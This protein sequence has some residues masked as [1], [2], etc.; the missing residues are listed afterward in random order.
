MDG[1]DATRLK[2]WIKEKF[3][4]EKRI[5]SKAE[6]LEKIDVELDSETKGSWSKT[7]SLE[8]LRKLEAMNA[9]SEVYL[10]PA[11]QKA[12]A[13][14]IQVEK[15]K[16]PIRIELEP[17]SEPV[18]Y[19]REDSKES[20]SF[21]AKEYAKGADWAT[22]NL[23]KEEYQKVR[24]WIDEKDKSKTKEDSER[25]INLVMGSPE[26]GDGQSDSYYKTDA[27]DKLK[28]LEKDYRGGDGY[29][30]SM[31]EKDYERLQTWI[32]DREEDP[33]RAIK[34]GKTED[35]KDKYLSKNLDKDVL[36]AAKE[37]LEK[38]PE[39]NKADLK[40]LDTWIAGERAGS[41]DANKTGQREDAEVTGDERI[42][43][44]GREFTK[45]TPLEEL[46]KFR[47][48]LKSS[49]FEDWLEPEQF[50]QLC[51]WIGTK[52]KYG[53]D[54]FKRGDKAQEKQGSRQ[55]WRGD[56]DASV[57]R[58]KRTAEEKLMNRDVRLDRSARW[59]NY[60]NEKSEQRQHLEGQRENLKAQ[61]RS[62]DKYEKERETVDGQYSEIW[63][64]DKSAI[65]A[66]PMGAASGGLRPLGANQFVRLLNQVGKNEERKRDLAERAEEKTQARLEGELTKDA[67]T[68]KAP[69]EKQPEKEAEKPEKK[70]E[71][72]KENKAAPVV[73]EPVAEKEPPAIDNSA[74]QTETK[75]LS[76][77]VK[78]KKAKEEDRD[79][80]PATD[81][82]RGER[83]DP[84]KYDPWGRY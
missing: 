26:D 53:E 35:G 11:E 30:R 10:D 74:L 69:E 39:A 68:W 78:N 83:E 4:E 62:L 8:E 43:H 79:K 22:E 36:Q 24:T 21:L 61:K 23:S 52:E 6:G 12:L 66:G 9:R 20:L 56:K 2:D 80:R 18:V 31:G 33:N 71:K 16:E 84:F 70:D 75:E 27:L 72:P 5:E 38:S 13:N 45:D 76:K 7:S 58:R 51:S 57:P 73:R 46:Q 17:G 77:D 63:G 54:A 42:E 59:D 67:K 19:D 65:A 55:E 29:V 47:Q 37:E 41:K 60:Y 32:A 40:L 64:A 34:F 48:E 28:E 1:D 25:P 3:R 14:W 49:R 81:P 44:L 50:S 15:L 82:N